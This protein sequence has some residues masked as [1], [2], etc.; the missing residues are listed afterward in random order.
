MPVTGKRTSP[1][2][3]ESVERRKRF[4]AALALAGMDAQDFAEMVAVTPAHVSMVLS[5]KR[6]S[7]VL[8]AKIDAFADKYL[9]K[10]STSATTAVA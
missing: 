7:E 8:C 1:T 2:I 9:G 5:G 4:R 6:E 3:V 10:R